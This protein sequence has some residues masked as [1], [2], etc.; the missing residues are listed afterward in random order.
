MR[1]WRLWAVAAAA[2]VAISG[3]A[4]ALL[5][6]AGSGY[7]DRTASR[8]AE[9]SAISGTVKSKLVA[10][11]DVKAVDVNV[12]THEGVVSL[13][14]DVRTAAQRVAAERVARTVKGVTGVKNQLRVK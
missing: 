2:T 6:S 11:P 7:E 4:A 8:I 12:E 14:G 3:C 10:A 5:G 13:Y 1:S 9:D